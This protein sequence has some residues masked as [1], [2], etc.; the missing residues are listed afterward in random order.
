MGAGW[1]LVAL[2]LFIAVGKGPPDFELI[3]LY[4]FGQEKLVAASLNLDLR[5]VQ[6][7]HIESQAEM[8]HLPKWWGLLRHP[9]FR[10]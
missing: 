6:V 4:F 8:G 2:F 5:W 10:Y 7:K 9:L 1:T 3:L